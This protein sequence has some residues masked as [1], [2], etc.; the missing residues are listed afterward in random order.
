MNTEVS[1][2]RP[3]ST[4]APAPSLPLRDWLPA[5]WSFV[6]ALAGCW[7]ILLPYALLALLADTEQGRDAVAA[8][9]A[10]AFDSAGLHAAL[11]QSFSVVFAMLAAHTLLT[12][13]RRGV[14]WSAAIV[15]S[16]A[17][18]NLL[19]AAPGMLRWKAYII[20][21]VPGLVGLMAGFVPLA[22]VEWQT[23]ATPKLYG[24]EVGLALAQLVPITSILYF[25]RPLIERRFLGG[26][27][28]LI[29]IA[30]FRGKRVDW[31]YELVFSALGILWLIVNALQFPQPILTMF[32]ASVVGFLTAQ[33][34]RRDEPPAAYFPSHAVMWACTAIA[35]FGG[36]L[37]A[38][39]PGW[40]GM[41]AGT[42]VVAMVSLNAWLGFAI[43][44]WRLLGSALASLAAVTTTVLVFTGPFGA[45]AVRF[46]PQKPTASV[47]AKQHALEWLRARADDIAHAPGRY[48]V[49][50]VTADGGG[51]RAA[52]WTA[53]ILARIQDRSPDFHRRS[54]ALS[55]VSG[56]SLGVAVFTSQAAQA[57]D[58]T[59]GG[60]RCAAG[61][62]SD[63]AKDVLRQD[64]L[65]PV[66]AAMLTVDLPRSVTRTSLLPDR[67]ASHEASFEE[68]WRRAAHADHFAESFSALWHGERRLKVPLLLLNTTDAVTG[69]RLVL[70]P[71]TLGDDTP[72][73]GDLAPL[74][75]EHEVRLS[76]AVLLSARFPGVS[77]AGRVPAQ[78]L[79]GREY[80]IV[81]GGFADNSGG[82]SALEA[83][84]ALTEAADELKVRQQIQPVAVVIRN[85]PVSSEPPPPIPPPVKEG[86]VGVLGALVGPVATLDR[87][88]QT[89]TQRARSEFLS[90]V[91][92]A[93]GCVLARFD[94][95]Q[96]ATTDFVLG[97]MLAPKARDA[98]VAQIALM[99]ADEHS[100][101]RNA[102]AL[103]GP[104]DRP[105]PPCNPSTTGQ[106]GQ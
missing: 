105:S 37:L 73:R 44:L 49:F 83:L 52:W 86:D 87:L 79:P 56:G 13:S 66:L 53:G 54:F 11:A 45:A 15:R 63:C 26:Q 51:I 27:S 17:K 42:Y 24:E 3:P 78:G 61:V 106:P 104:F 18:R 40:W 101:L 95:R 80:R 76:T 82:A 72:E 60:D 81:D 38:F 41:T 50:I 65:G 48:P 21:T 36:L 35:L 84:R 47:S 29:F 7:P 88:R 34:V 39:N 23:H 43:L 46:L 2:T 20:R 90:A 89:N 59:S 4:P 74:L 98:M 64:F 102:A 33:A 16:Y 14:R 99:E 85:D 57:A 1:Q 62:W 12:S 71:V 28:L 93:G 10:S 22:L 75:G 25:H 8:T 70:A 5:A 32:I 92:A 100:D 97:W 31:T 9:A 67:A 19:D 77:P 96:D 30:W 91:R 69:R 94:L 58:G 6:A 55:G 68:A 103:A